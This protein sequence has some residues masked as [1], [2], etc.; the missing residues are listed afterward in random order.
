ML[1][2]RIASKY[3]IFIQNVPM[4]TGMKGCRARQKIFCQKDDFS[5]LNVEND[6]RI[7]FVQKTFF[8]PQSFSRDTKNKECCF[9][10]SAEKF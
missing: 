3:P 6:E 8:V 1:K 4:E 7:F 10:N 9:D 2:N 5:L